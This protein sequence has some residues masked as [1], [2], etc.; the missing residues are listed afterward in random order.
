MTRSFALKASLLYA[1]VGSAYIA[2]SDR[3]LAQVV[4]HDTFVVLQ[5]Y[6]GFAFVAVTS[7]L[8]YYLLQRG[9]RKRGAAPG[10]GATRAPAVVSI[11]AALTLAIVG[12]GW[13][14]FQNMLATM[15]QKAFDEVRTVAELKA[16]DLGRWLQAQE[17]AAASLAANVAAQGV[18]DEL[19]LR[20]LDMASIR[21][22][23]A[24]R[25]A[26]FNFVS[27]DLIDN[28]A[29]SYFGAADQPP[30]LVAAAARAFGESAPGFV[31][32][33]VRSGAVGPRFGFVAPLP[34]TVSTGARRFAL[35]AELAAGDHL[36]PF[37]SAWPLPRATGAGIL[38]RRDGD[39]ALILTGLPGDAGAAL[40]LRVSF[41]GSDAPIVRFMRGEAETMRG[42]DPL[43][44]PVFASGASVPGTGW[45]LVA[46]VDESEA[47]AE[48]NHFARIVGL[49]VTLAI[50]AVWLIAG[51]VLQG[52]KLA[53]A[54]ADRKLQKRFRVTF[55]QAAVGMIHGDLH[56]GI[57]RVNRRACE[58]FGYTQ[59]EMLANHAL[60]MSAPEDTARQDSD[61]ESLRSG[62]QTEYFTER[63]YR[64]KDGSWFDASV[65]ASLAKGE[66]GEPDYVMIVLQD[67]S[68]RKATQAALEQSEERFRLALESAREGVWDWRP[69]SDE[70]YFSPGWKAMLGYG[71]DEIEN[72]ASA[73]RR[74]VADEGREAFRRQFLEIRA[75]QRRNF[76]FETRM[77]HRDGRWID[78]LSRGI[79]VF[80]AGGRMIRVVG[81][82]TDITERKRHE[83][84]RR[85]ASAVFVSTHEGVC[86][87][88]AQRNILMVNPAFEEITGYREAEV[89]GENPRVLKSGLHDDAF[90]QA[91][92]QD[93]GDKDYWR[94]EIWNKRKDGSVYPE[95][96][97]I[98]AVRDSLGVVTNYVA[99]FTDISRV[100]ESEERL[101]FLAHHD[102]LTSLPNRTLLSLRIAQALGR[103]RNAPTTAAVLF[104]DLDRFKTVNDSLGHAAGDELLALA[105]ERW[106]QALRPTDTLARVGGDEFVVLL[107]NLRDAHEAELI[108]RRL[109]AATSAPFTLAHE[110]EACVGLSVGASLFTPDAD[111]DALI[112]RADSALYLS[113]QSGGGALNFYSE[114]VTAEATARLAMEAGLRRA[115]ERGEFVL[116]YQPLVSLKDRAM[117]GVE[118]LVRWRGAG[119][120]VP[121]EQFIALAEKTGLIVPLGEFVLREACARMKVW[122]DAGAA[123]ESI[124]VNFSPVQLSRANIAERVA[125]ILAE[126]GLPPHCLEIE[127]TETA[128]AEPGEELEARLRALKNLGVRLAIDDFGAGH[129]SLFY[130]RRFPLDKLKLDRGFVQDIPRDPVSME[131]AVAI[132][133]LA[134]SLKV[135]ALAEGVETREQADFLAAS[136]CSLAQGYLFDKPLWE[137][138]LLQR[139]GVAGEERR[140]AG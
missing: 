48:K 19:D 51:F 27:V 73:W 88:D 64:R 46:R 20:G 122:R 102:P 23:L 30:E 66:A 125:A 115:L 29:R 47:L 65:S 104:L 62:A 35:Y 37:V 78:I 54:R 7:G 17:S 71:D 118:A 5:S 40:R 52:Q 134:N 116:Q 9:E 131:I 59:E 33:H 86:V 101:K 81:A 67:I 36:Y 16:G 140:A 123:I 89:R 38:A 70:A 114:D 84:Q 107:E 117:V 109:I 43:G 25:G 108:A 75:G 110:R 61:L 95:W 2:L 79:P 129:S 14:V 53:K 6:K 56:G 99:L 22:E 39:D 139:L 42:I 94:G 41:A 106:K 13:L 68:G 80:D 76:E 57:L 130:L 28:K 112:Q 83:A 85:L 21:T 103:A 12:A 113:K 92:W 82:D 74:A 121:P 119:G 124:S 60:L 105:S 10:A 69:D 132:I 11:A 98:S 111:A 137:E 3:F 8:L 93:I 4:D 15:E 100:K 63:R 90:Y 128:L 34:P 135:T 31:D 127:I 91:I 97:T 120:L 55:D 18:L 87:T 136:G 133:R 32:L 50:A 44:L 1:L 96:L 138:E 58:M 126:T 45:A 26:A 24:R 49:A 77:R 72:R